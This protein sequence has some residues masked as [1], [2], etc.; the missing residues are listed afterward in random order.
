[1]RYQRQEDIAAE[2]LLLQARQKL[3]EGNYALA[4]SIT[5]RAIRISPGYVHNYITLARIKLEQEDYVAAGQIAD[6][7]LSLID[8]NRWFFE[9]QEERSLRLISHRVKH[10]LSR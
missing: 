7:G 1:V 10:E 5:E 8:G 9:S 6:K 3:A 4:Q 2:Q